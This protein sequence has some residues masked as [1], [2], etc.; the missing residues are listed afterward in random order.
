[1][2]EERVAKLLERFR[3]FK[4]VKGS[5]GVIKVDYAYAAFAH[6]EFCSF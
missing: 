2:I 4:N 5:D 6:G 3:G 1:M